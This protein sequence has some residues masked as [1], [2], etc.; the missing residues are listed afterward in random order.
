MLKTGILIGE[1]FQDYSR[2]QDFE[3]EL[4]DYSS[5]SHLLSVSLLVNSPFKLK[6]VDILKE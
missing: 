5:I 1:S 2:I 4:T 3:A 6:N